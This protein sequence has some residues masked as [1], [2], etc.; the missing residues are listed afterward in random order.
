MYRIVTAAL[1]IVL[2]GVTLLSCSSATPIDL[3]G[4]KVI[5]LID[6]RFNYE[7]AT[8]TINY[9]EKLGADITIAGMVLDKNKP[10]DNDTETLTVE[11]LIEEADPNDFD[12]L[13]VPGGYSAE[14]LKNYG[15]VRS[16]V[17]SMH[18]QG[19]AVAAI[20]HGPVVLGH[21]GI[22]DGVQV[23]AVNS[24]EVYNELI[25]LGAVWVNAGGVVQSQGIVTGRTVSDL[26]SFNEAYAK[27]IMKSLN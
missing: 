11:L 16:L 10:Y 26:P 17:S 1:M 5:V 12:S 24:V 3:T 20:C 25:G 9:L 27:A 18:K 4:V 8:S 22:L 19:K 2:C 21:A 6:N 23:S 7:E 13:Y 15:E 14:S